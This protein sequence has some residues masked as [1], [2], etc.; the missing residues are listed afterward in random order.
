MKT[1]YKYLIQSGETLMPADA[2]IL[3]TGGQAGELYVW[4]LVNPESPPAPRRLRVI[5][6]GWPNQN[7]EGAFIGTVQTAGGMVFHVFD[8]GWA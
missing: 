7:Y 2:Q 1:I 5:G 3:S 6:T 4:A 8:E